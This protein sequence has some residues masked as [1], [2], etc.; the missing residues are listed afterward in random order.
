MCGITGCIA[1]RDAGLKR[2]DQVELSVHKLRQ[3]GPDGNGVFRH[4]HVALGHARLSIIDTSTNGAQPFSDESGRYT[5]VFNGE[6]FNFKP[7]RQQLESAGIQFRSESDTEVLLHLLIREGSSCIEK[8]NG[9]FAFAFYDRETGK[10]IIARDRY[11]EKPLVWMQDDDGLCFASEMKALLAYS[12]EKTLDHTS[13]LHY[14][15]LNYIP[16]PHSIFEQVQKLEPGHFMEIS[17]NV[18]RTE[19]WYAMPE[20]ISQPVPTYTEAQ[21]TLREKMEQAVERRMISDVPLGSFL[22]GGIDSSVVTA[23]ASRHTKN[24]NTFSIGY[25]DEPLFDETRYAQLV[26]S[27][28][29]TNH[30]VFSLRNKDL[31]D[32]LHG[33]LEYIDE[34]FADSSALA[35]NILCKETRKYATVALSG[36]GADELFGGYRKHEG[37]WNLRNGGIKASVVGMLG[38]VWDALPASRNSA[39]G[40][41]IRKLRKFSK[42]L[43]TNSSERYWNWCGYADESYLKAISAF[44]SNVQENSARKKYLTR[45]IGRT[46]DMNEMLLNDMHLVLPGD[47]LVKVDL[48]SMANGLEVRSPFLDY[49]VVDFAAGLPADYKISG[50]GRKRIVQDAFRTILPEEL[51][52]RPK[53]GFEVPLL[54]WFRTDLKSWIFDELLEK[55]F[56]EQQGLFRFEGISHLRKQLESGNP[57]DTT[58]RIWALLVFQNWYR[59]WMK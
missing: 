41:L 51:Y 14:L 37:E 15:H 39:S 13:L 12:F 4:H 38:P 29:G 17:G 20:K 3:R 59:Q 42:G 18:V 40:N 2:L 8:I 36:D 49:E 32:H 53:Q 9:F 28:Y 34:P 43:K 31:F 55:K 57:G 30:T 58:A 23:L 50:L 33:M 6:F 1:F 7:Y 11:G 10:I 27:K 5:L 26:A 16:A 47:M 35:V 44:S 25:G 54:Q 21:K 46:G 19:C 52:N 22:S 45:F 56:V 48:M 24:L